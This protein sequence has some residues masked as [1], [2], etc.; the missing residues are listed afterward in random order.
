MRAHNAYATS[1]FTYK[2]ALQSRDKPQADATY[3]LTHKKMNPQGRN[4][5]QAVRHGLKINTISAGCI[6]I[7]T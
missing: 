7:L 2:M 1:R 5:P 3:F 4:I 6:K